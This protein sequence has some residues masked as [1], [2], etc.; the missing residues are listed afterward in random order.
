VS[1]KLKLEACFASG[2]S[3]RGDAAVKLVL[4]AVET[5][6]LD[7]SIDCHTGDGLAD[8]GCRLLISSV[9]DRRPQRPIASTGRGQGLARFVIDNLAVNVLMAAE[10][11]QPRPRRRSVE[12]AANSLPPPLLLTL[13][14]LFVIQRF[15]LTQID[16]A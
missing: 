6:L 14:R 2:R 13:D 9:L 7:A 3:Q 15:T 12:R 8:V 16:D 4:S 11:A 5:N 1:V 10:H